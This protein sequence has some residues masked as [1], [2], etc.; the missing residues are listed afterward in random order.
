MNRKTEFP[1]KIRE[2]ENTWLTLADGTRLAAR[3]WLPLDAEQNPVPAL[4]EYLPYRKNDG[5]AVR[6]AD[7]H[8][9]LAAHGYACIR[10]D[11]RGNGD[12]DGLMRDEYLP[13]E[14]SDG[15]EVLRW[16][17]AQPWCDGNIGMFGKSWGGFNGL[18]IAALRP[19]E[20]KAI[21][22]ICSTDDRYADD[23]HYMGGCVLGSEMLS[24]ASYM[25]AYNAKPP[26]PRFVGD[27]W[28]EMWLNRLENTPPFVEEWLSHQ[29]R[30]AFWQH[31]SV[32]ENYGD[33]EIPV[34][35][36]G[37]WADGYTNA[38]FRL[39]AGLP[40]PRK[41][42]IGPW[43]H[44]FP[45]DSSPG[46]S[47]GFLQES[48]RWWDYWL[49]GIDTG[50]MDE[51]M[52]RIWL[53]ESQPPQIDYREW[54]GR[55]VAEPGWPSP[56]IQPQTYHLTTTQSLT[57]NL[58][59]PDD[60]QLTVSSLQTTGVDSA[61][62]LFFG[63]PGDFP[64]DQRAE[65]G[66]SLSFT[67]D[68][69][70]EPMEIVGFPEVTLCFTVDQPQAVVAAWL[71]DVAP[72]GESTRISW[73]LFNL[74]HRSGHAQPEPLEPGKEYSVTFPL[75]ALAHQLPVGH[76]WRLSLSTT[77]W[78]HLWPSPR[79]VLLTV[80]T[81]KSGLA[82]PQRPVRAE[83]EDLRPFGPAE[84][85]L[86]LPITMLRPS[87]NQRLLRQDAM[88]QRLE[89]DVITDAGRILFPD[90]LE[91]DNTARDSY[92][93]TEGDPLSATAV[94]VRTAELKRGD[95]EVRLATHSEMT[96]DATHF[97]LRNK[98]EAWEGKT[99]VFAK[100]YRKSIPRDLV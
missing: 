65:N 54:P 27:K 56:T 53:Q 23:V 61:R 38:V 85:S 96:A 97:H 66:R 29:Q 75:N 28:R 73:G 86:P 70:T 63:A 21:I 69:M 49:K 91:Y 59:S 78:P 20:L 37:G 84:G 42:L 30:D 11:M 13:Q 40:G 99:A 64:P 83:D 94:C 71:C 12:S 35:A 90:G 60:G 33:I 98:M 43:A 32:C 10:V 2:V 9:Y 45:E 5:T 93:I 22:T 81:G 25:L 77:Y 95:W 4:L 89:V 52:F 48:L 3:L 8:P 68:P 7:R 31:G 79:P 82:L 62:W 47:I 36:V 58:Q 18:Q 17:A 15:C 55:W 44:N 67:S 34:Y 19:P 72:T 14:L 39:L 74:T 46:P 100:E 76:C 50:I 26:D 41:G 57:S 6:D 24:W 16:I 51:P 1:H 87:G 88:T 80:H 92:A